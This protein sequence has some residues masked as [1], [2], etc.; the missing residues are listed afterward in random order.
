MLVCGS[1]D[2]TMDKVAGGQAERESVTRGMRHTD[3]MLAGA[4]DM[5]EPPSGV[6]AAE[7]GGDC[8]SSGLLNFECRTRFVETSGE[9]R[10]MR[11]PGFVINLHRR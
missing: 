10:V 11:P 2:N 8:G 9:L 3:R 5:M 7:R 6:S 4:A 1:A